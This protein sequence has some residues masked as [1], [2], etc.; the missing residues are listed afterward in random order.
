MT[1]SIIMLVSLAITTQTPPNPNKSPLE[2]LFNCQ[3]I[4][5][6]IAQNSCFLS[7]TSKLKSS[8]LNGDLI[9]VDQALAEQQSIQNFGRHR[10]DSLASSLDIEA[11]DQIFSALASSESSVDG[12]Y[13]FNLEDGSSWLQTDSDIIRLKP[14]NGTEA[15][16]KRASMGSYFLRLGNGRDIRVRRID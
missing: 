4:T 3:T 7:E 9:V 10:D 11:P 15:T 5:D 1:P 16:V 12:K 6:P 2:S 13:R 8:L 14:R